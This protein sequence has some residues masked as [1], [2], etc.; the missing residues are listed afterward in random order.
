MPDAQ[1]EP[2]ASPAGGA[3]G[4]GPAGEVDDV[5]AGGVAV[6]DLREEQGDGGD[7]AEPPLAPAMMLVA[8]GL[9]NRLGAQAGGEVL[10]QSRQ[11]GEDP[12]R[13]GRAPSGTGV[14]RF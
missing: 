6:E 2:L 7:R 1:G 8:A 4:G 13:H 12:W 11:D 9:A 10:A 3:G 5:L 14:G